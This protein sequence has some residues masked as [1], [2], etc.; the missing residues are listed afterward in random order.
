MV[1][2]YIAPARRTDWRFADH[3]ACTERN[4]SKMK[5][6]E[7]NIGL[8][9]A[10]GLC[11]MAQDKRL[12]FL[13][14]GLPIIL[15]SAQSLWR[16]SRK[17]H[18]EMPREAGVLYGFAQEE[19]A[20]VLIFMDAVRCPSHLIASKMGA[21]VKCSYDHLAR[22]IYAK[23][24][25]WRLSNVAELRQYVDL[26]R[27]THDREGYVGEYIVPNWN[28]YERESRLYADIEADES[29]GLTWN[30]PLKRAFTF[31]TKRHPPMALLLVEAMASL[32][33]FTFAGLKATSEIWGQVEF[34]DKE[35]RSDARRLTQELVDR[36]IEEGLPSDKE[37]QQHVR[38]L[39]DWQLPMYNLDFAKRT[40]SLE[41]L[42][43]ARE[44]EF[45]SSV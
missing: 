1:K 17:L 36:L 45:W 28:Q 35:G 22:L 31:T 14:E 41:E 16:G 6:G 40:V 20:K 29:G 33:I 15:S 18:K 7:P 43:A 24:S 39:D 27:N 42:R 10:Q 21:I 4:G 38:T 30:N 25:S 12:A 26:N 23:A 34:A 5:P 44:A 2:G 8:H 9:Q 3:L 19:A 13:A 37:T 11:R 32:G